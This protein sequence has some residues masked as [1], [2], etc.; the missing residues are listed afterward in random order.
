MH[1]V[2]Y[3]LHAERMPA[4]MPEPVGILRETTHFEIRKSELTRTEK[5]QETSSI[6]KSCF[7]YFVIGFV[8]EPTQ[9][10]G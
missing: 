8:V 9:C 6:G 5:I 7:C 1:Q 4:R 10:H 3:V 2:N